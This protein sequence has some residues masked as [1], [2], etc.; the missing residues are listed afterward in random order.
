MVT[1]TGSIGINKY[2]AL[3][4]DVNT[5]K[6]Y[7]LVMKQALPSSLQPFLQVKQP[8]WSNDAHRI[9]QVH[10]RMQHI[11]PGELGIL[12]LGNDWYII[13][14]IQPEADKITLTNFLSEQKE[15]L[16][17]MDTI[18]SLTA[19]AQLRSGGRDGSAITDEMI[20]FSTQR[21]WIKPLLAFAGAYAVQVEKDYQEY[22]NDYDKGY[23]K[24]RSQKK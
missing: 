24:V 21:E 17:L 5:N 20:R 13:G 4:S 22:C 16:I 15:Q 1:G 12:P 8:A 2:L 19:S 3:A 11:T 9:S 18:G 10:F 6:K 7:L 14:W 23:F